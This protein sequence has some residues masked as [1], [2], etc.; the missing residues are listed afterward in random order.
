[1]KNNQIGDGHRV[2]YSY[3]AKMEIGRNKWISLLCL[4]VFSLGS[5]NAVYSPLFRDLIQTDNFSI[6]VV[7]DVETV[8]L[9]GA[10]KVNTIYYY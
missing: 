8:E 4:F 1:M 9:C 10:L 3:V 5:R 2:K 6:Y 7:D